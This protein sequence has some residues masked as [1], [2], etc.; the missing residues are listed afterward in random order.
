L[1]SFFVFL[2]EV[3]TTRHRRIS[4]RRPF[5]CYTP[6]PRP[7]PLNAFVK[8]APSPCC[9]SRPRDHR[10]SVG[11]RVRLERYRGGQGGR[12]SVGTALGWGREGG[13]TGGVSL[14]GGK[15]KGAMV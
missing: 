4:I 5:F 13:G 7:I 10:R 12:D 14:E 11:P 15:D 2:C 9:V 1:I 6:P 3:R 8:R